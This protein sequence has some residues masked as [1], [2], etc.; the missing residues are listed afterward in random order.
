M[1]NLNFL[2]LTVAALSLV[3][4]GLMIP[5]NE[6][7]ALMKFK[8]GE[9]E[10]ARAAYQSLLEQGRATP[11]EIRQLSDIY[12]ASEMPRKAA[13]AYAL[14]IEGTEADED[15]L[16]HLADLYLQSEQ[17]DAYAKTLEKIYQRNQDE[18]SLNRLIEAYELLGDHQKQAEKLIEQE[19]RFGLSVE[20]KLKLAQTL[21]LLHE[22]VKAD[23]LFQQLDQMDVLKLGHEEQ[24]AYYQVAYALSSTWQTVPVLENLVSSPNP[25]P[26]LINDLASIYAQR[27]QSKRAATFFAKLRNTAPSPEVDLIWAKFALESGDLAAVHQWLEKQDSLSLETLESLYYLAAEHPSSPLALSLLSKLADQSNKAE[28]RHAKLDLLLEH[29]E[30][31][32]ALTL[33]NQLQAQGELSQRQ[34][35][36]YL[37]Q[38]ASEQQKL[39]YYS[40]RSQTASLGQE[41]QLQYVDKLLEKRQK[42][43]ALKALLKLAEGKGAD[44]KITQKL[45]YL[46]GPSA[47][48]EALD[49]IQHRAQTAPLVEKTAWLKHLLNAGGEARLPL[50]LGAS[51]SIT[52]SEADSL[53]IEA[54]VNN[55]G[56]HRALPSIKQAIARDRNPK[57]LKRYA[58]WL[59]KTGEKQLAAAT[60]QK[61]LKI[62]PDAS[63][64]QRWL[65]NYW[66]EKGESQTAL[67][68]L[69]PYLRHHP[70]D[71]EANVMAANI[72]GDT[73]Q[74]DHEQEFLRRALSLLSSRP[75]PPSFANELLKAQILERL[76][77]KPAAIKAYAQ[78]LASHPNNTDVRAGYASLLLQ[79]GQIEES[80]R[81]LKLKN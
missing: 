48:N 19:R 47:N 49:W 30:P 29:G 51:W 43:A 63:F 67:R 13:E 39:D 71:Y 80:K 8:D 37:E 65:A 70:Q 72:Y 32:E 61:L 23:A 42:N 62:S 40:L 79:T 68:Y 11:F 1:L 45:L 10:G 33:A 38:L 69:L 27:R 58:W 60:R 14:Y 24:L 21:V 5:R 17:P 18:V 25:E 81:I 57:R 20:K 78:L 53:L 6:E 28:W 74:K 31:R 44:S 22:L 76:E 35:E 15:K 50:L 7:V 34:Y 59:E 16:N 4:G 46:W 56:I 54:V 52:G 36:Y 77:Q 66:L 64:E 75:H 2:V 73:G 9:L 41:K 12:L 55:H 3:L 26:S